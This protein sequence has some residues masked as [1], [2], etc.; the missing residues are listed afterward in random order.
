[1]EINVLTF[2]IKSCKERLSSG[3]FCDSVTTINDQSEEKV[4]SLLLIILVKNIARKIFTL[5]LS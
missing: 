5:K 4:K 1:M 3:L 2:W